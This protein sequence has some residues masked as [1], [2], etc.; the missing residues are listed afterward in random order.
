MNTTFDSFEEMF[1]VVL[2]GGNSMSARDKRD[3]LEKHFTDIAK[4]DAILLYRKE[5]DTYD[6]SLLENHKYQLL[7]ERMRLLCDKYQSLEDE[8]EENDK[9]YMKLM[10]ESEALLPPKPQLPAITVPELSIIKELY[11]KVYDS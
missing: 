9:E 8:L 4:N 3:L 1:E 11:N 5:R 7:R 2:G 6:K 10:R